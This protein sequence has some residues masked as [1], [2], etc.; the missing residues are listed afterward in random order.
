MVPSSRVQITVVEKTQQWKREAS[1]YFTCETQKQKTH[2]CAQ[3]AF[4]LLGGTRTPGGGTV[5]S[6][7]RVALS[8]SINLI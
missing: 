5:P 4:S 1:G 8:T 3:L 6:T 2:A 7:F